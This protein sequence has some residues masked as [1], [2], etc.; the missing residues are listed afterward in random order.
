MIEQKFYLKETKTIYLHNSLKSK[1]E[2][3]DIVI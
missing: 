3:Y 1:N 2:E